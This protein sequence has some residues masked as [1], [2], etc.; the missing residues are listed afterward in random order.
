MNEDINNLCSV[1]IGQIRTLYLKVGL[2][3]ARDLRLLLSAIHSERFFQSEFSGYTIF[4]FEHV[5]FM[6]VNPVIT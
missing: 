2:E 1:E 4:T 5:L 6:L 3:D